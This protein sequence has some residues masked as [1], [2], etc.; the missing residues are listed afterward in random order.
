[1]GQDIL[2]N[3]GFTG[4]M[5]KVGLGIGSTPAE[6]S[7][8]NPSGTGLE[9]AIDGLAYYKVDDAT[10]AMSAMSVQADLTS[11]LYLVELD[12]AG[13]LTTKKGVEVLTANLGVVGG[14]LQWPPPSADKCPIGGF[15]V[16]L[17]GATFTGATTDLDASGVT[18][19][20]YDFAGGIPLAPITS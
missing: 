8:A 6:L 2:A 12:A 17:D 11:C 16:A 5:S 18:D 19:T 10:V 15:K 4:A 20:Y 13:A 7:T 1:M 14:T 9:F 3:S